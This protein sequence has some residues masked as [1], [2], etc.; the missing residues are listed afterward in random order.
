M[1]I[2]YILFLLVMI[3]GMSSCYDDKGNY[4]YD[5]KNDITV[6]FDASYFEAV[7]GETVKLS[8][9]LIF[10]I[11]SNDVDLSYEWIFLG[12]KISDQRNLEWVV[13][14]VVNYQSIYMNVIDNR[15]GVAYSGGI[16][17]LLTS[18]Y[19]KEAWVVLAKQNGKSVLSYIREKNED[20][21]SDYGKFTYEDV[22]D[23]YR[24][25]NDEEL[26]SEP[27][28]VLEH[29]AGGG[30]LGNFWVLQNGGQGCVDLSGQD[31]TK[32]VL[33]N[34]IFLDGNLPT[35]FKPID[36]I[37]MKWLTCV[38]NHDGKVYTRK[39]LTDQLY[40]SGYFIDRPLI[41]EGEEVDGS[42]FV[43]APFAGLGF[44]V[45]YDKVNNRFLAISDL[46]KEVAGKV[47]KFAVDES[48]YAPDFA[49]LNDLGTMEVLHT[50]YYEVNEGRGDQGYYSILR[51]R[52]TGNYYTHDFR[53][54]EMKESANPSAFPVLQRQIDLSQV[55]NGTSKNVF[56]VLRSWVFGKD[57]G[58]PYV[59]I[60]KD[61][62][63]WLY[64]R[65]AKLPVE[66]YYEFPQG[67]IITAI[68]SECVGSRRVAIGMQSGEFYVLDLTRKAVNGQKEKLLYAS[69]HDFGEIVHIRY[70]VGYGNS[71]SF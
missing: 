32:D 48:A 33:L 50:G 22:P 42:R 30:D 58:T 64:D 27:V 24:L 56:N 28:R 52:T 18:P 41:F 70:K 60:S 51:D 61:N 7:L 19:A 8:P 54:N 12:R 39:K 53:V 40:N 43:L 21:G 46:S 25:V 71:W 38:V 67:Q 36:M 37:D 23:I 9:K 68:D 6:T 55:I 65:D 14:T 59:L 49:R 29:F 20:D 17:A 11:D 31:F 69:T 4:S 2:R 3:L 66:K 34:N 26:G 10:A 57:F 16:S 62:E 5:P 15:T 35:D 13:D 63:L 44:T 47:F 45:M 1:K